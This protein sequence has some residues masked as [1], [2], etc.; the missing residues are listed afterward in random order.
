M[1]CMVAS[2]RG[3]PDF[4]MDGM[5][6]DSFRSD[7]SG[8]RLVTER[9]S[10]R[11][12]GP[13]LRLQK[14]DANELLPA[15]LGRA[16]FK[17]L[18]APANG[19]NTARVLWRKTDALKLAVFLSPRIPAILLSVNSRCNVENEVRK[20]YLGKLRC[21]GCRYSSVIT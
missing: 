21:G 15:N 18:P 6:L 1:I 3:K 11:R 9:V 19:R 12:V 4:P 20:T 14:D 7:T 8:V 13:G 16:A 10:Q 5:S 17:Q 2:R